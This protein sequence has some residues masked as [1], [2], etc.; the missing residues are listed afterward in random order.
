MTYVSKLDIVTRARR[1]T[2]LDDAAQAAL[3]AAEWAA[4]TNSAVEASITADPAWVLP[5]FQQL[6]PRHPAELVTMKAG[7]DLAGVAILE[8]TRW[9]WGIPINTWVSWSHAHHFLGTPLMNA[10]SAVQGFTDLIARGDVI[11]LTQMTLQGA[12]MA[13]LREAAD[14]TGARLSV[15]AAHERACYR[16]D[17]SFA[18]YFATAFPRKRRKEFRRLR[19][20][21]EELGTVRF[22]SLSARDDI[23]AWFDRFE[24]LEASGWKGRNRT[25]IAQD[26][27]SSRFFREVAQRLKSDGRL[28]FWE[29]SLD[30]A[31][32]AMLFAMISGTQAWLGKIAYDESLARF[33]PGVLLMLDVTAE[34]DRRADLTLVDSCAVP[35]HPMIDHLWHDR[36]PIGDVLVTPQTVPEWRA[37]S[38]HL[39]EIG[40]NRTLA[41]W[42]SARTSLFGRS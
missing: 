42:R 15:T 4:L 22:R 1:S 18:E 27:Q 39:L 7:H 20:R 33:S 40:R 36:L 26:P 2:G 13:A 34:L 5:A 8:H 11:L 17:G 19:A 6:A 29:L 9:R 31:P 30:G 37:R 12:A 41:A 32:I 25:A 24:A 14:E 3:S 38:L 16:P 35:G 10:R 23:A 21:L 28:L